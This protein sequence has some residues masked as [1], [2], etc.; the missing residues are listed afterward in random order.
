[1]FFQVLLDV[2]RER[3]WWRP[4]VV[5]LEAHPAFRGVIPNAWEEGYN[6]DPLARIRRIVSHQLGWC[7]QGCSTY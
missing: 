6:L 4:N 1:V 3:D 5:N 2:R 7:V